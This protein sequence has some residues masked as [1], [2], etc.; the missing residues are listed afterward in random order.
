MRQEHLTAAGSWQG[1]DGAPAASWVEDAGTPEALSSGGGGE[2][3]RLGAG[4]ST[5]PLSGARGWQEGRVHLQLPTLVFGNPSL[6]PGKRRPGPCRL[7]FSGL[8]LAR[9]RAQ[10]CTRLAGSGAGAGAVGPSSRP[11]PKAT[12]LRAPPLVSLRLC[13]SASLSL[14]LSPSVTFSSLFCFTSLKFLFTT[15]LV[16]FQEEAK[17]NGC[18]Q[19][20]IFF[21]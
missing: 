19:S 16:A 12:T 2:G 9:C 13:V 1:V 18:N 20:V 21:W 8:H 17:I 3:C 14:S 5:V 15:I 4:G 7:V 10:P 11:A 6:S